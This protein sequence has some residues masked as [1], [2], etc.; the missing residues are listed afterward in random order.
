MK[1]KR[2][3]GEVREKGDKKVKGGRS[4][5]AS[6]DIPSEELEKCFRN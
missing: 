2:R 1:K 5:Q 3:Y 6:Y 4:M